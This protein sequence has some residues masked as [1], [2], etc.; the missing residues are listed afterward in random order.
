MQENEFNYIL[1]LK[2]KKM[3]KIMI[4]STIR[5]DFLRF[6]TAEYP[7]VIALLIIFQTCKS[8]CIIKLCFYGRCHPFVCIMY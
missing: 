2:T 5:E 6:T 1:L 8:V 7:S 3:F 4:T